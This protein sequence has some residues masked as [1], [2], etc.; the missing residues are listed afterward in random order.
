MTPSHKSIQYKLR[1]DVHIKSYGCQPRNWKSSTGISLASSTLSKHTLALPFRGR[2]TAQRIFPS[3]ALIDDP[4]S[5]R[6][7]LVGEE[8][9]TALTGE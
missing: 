4:A 9:Y 7:T 1:V 2:L 6:T 5:P 3:I 8:F